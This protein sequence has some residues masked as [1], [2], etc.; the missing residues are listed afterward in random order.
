MKSPRLRF[1]WRDSFRFRE[2]CQTIRQRNKCEVDMSKNKISY[3]RRDS[4]SPAP[5]L[6]L[7]IF[8]L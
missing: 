4:Y 1:F 2:L 3:T 7:A 5:W 6:F 8:A